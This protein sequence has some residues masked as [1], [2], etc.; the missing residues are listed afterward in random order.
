MALREEL[1][2]RPHRVFLADVVLDGIDLEEH[3]VGRELVGI[4]LED[5]ELQV[6][7]RLILAFARRGFSTLDRTVLRNFDE[8][9][10]IIGCLR[11]LI[12]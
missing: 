6:R 2:S 11:P 1:L 9:I 7:D 10:V 12:S 5:L 4:V 8:G 3:I